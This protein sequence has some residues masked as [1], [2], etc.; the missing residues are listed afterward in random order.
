MNKRTVSTV[1][2]LLLAGF[3]A[4]QQRGVEPVAP[5]VPRES[6]RLPDPAAA[7]FARRARG[8]WM[9]VQGEV[10]RILADDNDGSRHQRFILRTSESHTVLVAHNIDLAP[11]LEGLR[12]GEGLSLRGEYEWNERGGVLHW[13]HHDPQGR[14]S[15]GYIDRMGRR[16]Q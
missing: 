9:T 5:D 4:W 12:E 13:T 1:V 15:G 2:A 10:D 14:R 7:A 3:W 8:E 11:R 6:A 16:Y